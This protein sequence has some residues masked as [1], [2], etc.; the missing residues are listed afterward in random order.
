M[1][2]DTECQ[3]LASRSVNVE[4]VAVL[5]KL[6][7]VAAGRTDEHHHH[8]TS[9]HCLV[10]VGDVARHVARD[11]WCGRLVAQ[12]FLD[13]RG[14]QRRVIN[15]FAP[16]VRMFCE[17]LSRPTDEPRGGFVSCTCDHVD[18]DQQFFSG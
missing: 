16:L 6:T 8:A 12:Q 5:A 9:W 1:R 18:V 14:Y 4:L 7:V 10:V 3:M 15:E 17:N 13:G 2:T 11:M